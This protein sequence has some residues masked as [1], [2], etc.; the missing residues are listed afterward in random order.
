MGYGAAFMVWRT[1]IF[2]QLDFVWIVIA[3]GQAVFA[4]LG[5]VC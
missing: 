1:V 3:H 4:D 2:N 5:K